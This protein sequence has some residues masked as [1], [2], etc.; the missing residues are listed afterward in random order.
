MGGVLPHGCRPRLIKGWPLLP[1][2]R[3]HSKH[4]EF[5]A[6]TPS[7]QPLS[8]PTSPSP[9]PRSCVLEALRACG[10]VE[11]ASSEEQPEDLELGGRGYSV[12]FDP[13]DG[14]SIIG[15]NWAVRGRRLRRLAG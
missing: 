13:L 1:T 9:R 5:A 2:E 15:A 3:P 10:A 4:R 6:C 11:L 14:S 12:A 8:E 7:F